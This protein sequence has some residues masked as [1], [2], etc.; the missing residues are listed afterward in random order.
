MP[1]DRTVRQMHPV[2]REP[3]PADRNMPDVPDRAGRA[4]LRAELVD[5]RERMRRL[6]LGYSEIASEIA[7]RYRLR[8]RE[9]Y[10]L[11]W[12]WTPEHAAARFNALAVGEGAGPQHHMGLTG[13]Q[14][15]EHER[16]PAGGRKPPVRVL[17]LLA[18]MY[19]TDVGCLLDLADHENLAPPDR[20]TLTGPPQPGQT[21]FGIKLAALIEERGMSLREAARHAGY[22]AGYLSNVM[23]GRK[24]ATDQIASLL[25]DLLDADG[26]LIALAKAAA[27][28]SK[29]AARRNRRGQNRATRAA[30][31]E[32]LSLSLPDGPCHLVIEISGP[33][34][35][36]GRRVSDSDGRKTVSGRL[37]LIPGT[38]SPGAGRTKATRA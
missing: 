11:A 37:A 32:S 10:R 22:S 29:P 5:L 8:P 28:D 27:R 31:T 19:Q 21:L 25:D 15:R 34:A 2:M 13:S 24:R 35:S 17:L 4:D 20:I 30:Q 26:E 14:L 3:A 1:A 7:R 38:A 33:D 23:H 9:A 6:G 36:P 12:G 18:Q 16:W